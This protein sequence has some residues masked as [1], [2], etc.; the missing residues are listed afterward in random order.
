MDAG[1]LFQVRTR[2]RADS[3]A[4]GT[5]R[6]LC[7]ALVALL[8]RL[9]TGEFGLHV[10]RVRARRKGGEGGEGLIPPPLVVHGRAEQ[11]F[12][13]AD[14]RLG[15]VPSNAAVCSAQLPHCALRL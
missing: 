6:R 9:P 14:A 3:N 2:D 4:N 1:D 11:P 8:R 10:R 13:G 15:P 5:C 12:G 7:V